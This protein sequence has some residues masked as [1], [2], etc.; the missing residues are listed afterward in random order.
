M[1]LPTGP[2]VT[3]EDDLP[4]SL[5]EAA[6]SELCDLWADLDEACRSAINTVWSIRCGNVAFRIVALSRFVGATSWDNV[7]V[8]LLLAGIYE[9]VYREAGIDYDPIDWERVRETEARIEGRR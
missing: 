1:T 7:S 5:E 6:R 2:L 4:D 8:D 9:R 3:V